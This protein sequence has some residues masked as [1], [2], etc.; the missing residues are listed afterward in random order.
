M[1]G[2]G[3]TEATEWIE[4]TEGTSVE[5][6]TLSAFSGSKLGRWLDGRLSAEPEQSDVV[7]DLLAHLAEQMIE[8]Y[9]RCWPASRPPTGS[10]ISS[11]IG[12][13]G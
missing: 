5:S 3:I 12:C 10:L 1:V 2:V 9:K 4:S 13:T 6:A 7:H 11:S 8:M